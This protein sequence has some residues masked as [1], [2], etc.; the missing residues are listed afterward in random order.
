MTQ[1]KVNMAMVKNT[2]IRLV[3]LDEEP[4]EEDIT[5]IQEI[6]PVEE[7]TPTPVAKVAPVEDAAPQRSSPENEAITRRVPAVSASPTPAATPA[8]VPCPPLPK[9]A[10]SWRKFVPVLVA[11]VPVIGLTTA[12][13][14]SRPAKAPEV[15][16]PAPAPTAPSPAPAPVAA[17]HLPAAVAPSLG[18]KTPDV[19]R[20]QITV[21]PVQAE[22]GL[23]GNVLA[24]HRL[25][26][27]VPKDRGVHVVSAS[28]PGY[29]PFNQQVVF[30]ND[31]VL[32]ITLRRSSHAPA[33]RPSARQRTEAKTQASSRAAAVAA[34]P[35]E[36]KPQTVKPRPTSGRME[37]GMDLDNPAPRH[38]A[39]SLDERNPYRP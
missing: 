29:L 39:K 21:D 11:L 32:N 9:A 4:P 16:A 35:V 38:G 30:S 8:L 18:T 3:A 36:S 12:W 7:T 10:P 17:P 22:L 24:G 5:Q 15:A 13:L 19:I 1:R 26:L 28:A 2:P 33:A 6:V 27:E 20:L 31:V 37:P 23:D 25:N 34:P 14:V